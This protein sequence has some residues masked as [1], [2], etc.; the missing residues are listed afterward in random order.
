MSSWIRNVC[1]NIFLSENYLQALIDDVILRYVDFVD[2]SPYETMGPV[3]SM[4]FG[5]LEEIKTMRQLSHK[6][7]AI[8]GARQ[9]GKTSLMLKVR[10]L[11]CNDAKIKT[12]YLDCS[13]YYDPLALCQA[14]I[15]GITFEICR[16]RSVA[17]GSNHN[18]GVRSQE[19]R[20]QKL[21]GD[22][23]KVTIESLG[24]FK[25][26]VHE[27]CKKEGIKLALFLD[28]IDTLLSIDKEMNGL[29]FKTFRALSQENVISLYVA[30][31]EELF[32]RT[33]DIK[34]PLFNYMELIRL[35]SLDKRSASQ[36]VT[37]P[38]KELGIRIQDE[39]AVVEEICEISSC[40]PNLI[41]YICKRLIHLIAS[42]RRRVIYPT[43]L[44]TGKKRSGLPRLSFKQVF[45]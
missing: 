5:R 38:I 37:E 21:T 11:I 42:Q 25:K 19:R 34:S 22:N 20:S 28:E 4:F 33:K 44:A 1:K 39:K 32:I 3:D 14:I 7:F 17:D 30:G 36:L 40:F 8:I 29:L 26:A 23:P 41:Q 27:L 45:Y 6:S 12:L 15:D 16:N 2:L 43:D 9:L 18:R 31:Y 10:N 35:G 24:D 13:T